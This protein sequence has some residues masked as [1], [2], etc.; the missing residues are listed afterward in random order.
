[1]GKASVYHHSFA[2]GVND[3]SSLP[4]TDLE[5][6]RLAA[7]EQTNLM[8][9]ATGRGFLRPGLEFLGS[10]YQVSKGRL[11]EFVFGTSDA[12]LFELSDFHL[13]FW[14]A[15]QLVTR[16]S[17]DCT[18]PNG[19][20]ATGASWVDDSTDGATST[21]GSGVMDLNALA[22]GSIA[23]SKQLITTGTPG[24]EHGLRIDIARGPLTLRVGSTDGGDEYVA[25]TS[26]RSGAH[27]IAFTPAGSFWI[28]FESDSR[29]LRRVDN[30]ALD[31]AGVLVMPSIWGVDDLP[32]LRMAQSADVVFVACRG[33]IQQRIERRGLRGQGRSWSV[34]N[35]EANDGPFSASRTSTVRLAPSVCEGSGS[36]TSDR[37]FF[38]PEHARDGVNTGGTLFKLSQT[39]QVVT[40]NLSGSGQYTD[41]IEVT[42]INNSAATD[43]EDQYDDRRWSWSVAGTWVGTLKVFRSFD[44]P[45]FGYKEYR[46]GETAATIDVTANASFD[47]T[48]DDNNAIV[49]YRIGFED[50]AYT[51]GMAEIICSYTGGG[52]SGIARVTGYVS[53]TEV[54]MDVVRPFKS[55]NFTDD[56]QEGQWSP[57]SGYPTA[58]A[59]FEGRLWWADRDRLWGSTSDDFENFDEDIEGDSGP[60]NRVVATGGVNDTQWMLPLQ[61]LL[62]GTDGTETTARSSSFDEPLT[63]TNTTLKDASTIGAEAVDAVRMDSRALFIDRSGMGIFESNFDVDSADY[64]TSELSKLT[65][66]IFGSGILGLAVQ[67][68]PDTRI[69]AWMENGTAVCIVY[70]PKQEVVAFIPIETDGLIESIAVLPAKPH[71]RPYFIVQRTID[72]TPVRY[73]EKMAT[74]KESRPATLCKVMDSFRSGTNIVPTAVI[75]GATHLAGRTVVVWADGAPLTQ[76]V[77]GRTVPATFAVSAGGAIT[78]PGAVTNYVYGLPYQWRYKS[79]RLAYGAQGGTAMLKK[80]RIDQ[81]GI[82]MTDFVRAGVSYGRAF[83]DVNH[84][85]MPLPV[86]QDRQVAPAIVISD[87]HDEEAFVFEGDWDT[88]SR[89][90]LEGQSPFPVSLLGLVIDMTTSS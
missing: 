24:V 70:D 22:R 87:V 5:R 61:R 77:G 50:G 89:I 6:M 53:P 63:P 44:G 41:P 60:I 9:L 12:S 66:D 57:I 75:T 82:I 76:E 64:S 1:M 84:P 59:L 48:D 72:G 90:C 26:L 36:L 33:K 81:L 79:A 43:P 10:T 27:S 37:P 80:K 54:N 51:S 18:I 88:D 32:L 46:A 29:L 4:R 23:R 19:T 31:A 16:P 25:A 56:W 34:V 42:G 35:Y 17:V 71:D 7:E 20:F 14:V 78:L 55:N 49:W 73:V 28:Q 8:C 83:D 67:R 21:I 11:K 52:G 68:R 65:Q 39:G 30:V 69:W 13:R 45:D 47:N 3:K 58:N 86:L 15:D 74:D 2:T 40:T 85:L 38:K 62:L